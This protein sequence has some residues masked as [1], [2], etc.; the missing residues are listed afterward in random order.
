[1]EPT[2][3]P[4]TTTQSGFELA[5]QYDLSS[6]EDSL[7]WASGFGFLAN[8]TFQ[9]YKGGSVVN[10]TSGRGLNVLGD[11]SLEQGLLNFSETAYNLTMFYEKFGLSAR[12]RYTWREGFF[13]TDFAG[14][15]STS[16]TFSFPVYTEDRGQL[17][18]S[19][20]Y[21]VNDNF[22]VGIEVT[23]LT[24]EGVIQRCVSETGP[25]CFVG[26]PDRRIIFGG[27]YRF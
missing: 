5:F 17:N 26:L 24:E 9:D 8:A 20:N 19:I 21:D 23:N 13:N 4:E 25:L 7:G 14:G 10:T 1:S 2:N 15:A 22:N 12:A 11:V 18:A 6:F 16:S 3:D 27:S